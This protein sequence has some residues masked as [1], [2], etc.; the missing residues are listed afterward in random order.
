MSYPKLI[1]FN[2]R[3]GNTDPGFTTG[4]SEVVRESDDPLPRRYRFL[5]SAIRGRVFH[6]R[7]FQLFFLSM[8]GLAFMAISSPLYHHL[9]HQR[10]TNRF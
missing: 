5:I 7:I 8:G 6:S 3:I 4:L 9:Q 10:S 2:L 1:F